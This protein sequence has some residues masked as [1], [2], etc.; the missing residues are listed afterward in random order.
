MF[1]SNMKVIFI[2]WNSNCDRVEVLGCTV[3]AKCSSECAF[4]LWEE[5]HCFN[6]FFLNSETQLA[7]SAVSTGNGSSGSQLSDVVN[8]MG[9]SVTDVPTEQRVKTKLEVN[10]TDESEEI[11]EFKP[12][13]I[14]SA[15][16]PQQNPSNGG[17]VS[18]SETLPGSKDK[19]KSEEIGVK[20][21]EEGLD[22][23]ETG[24]G[25]SSFG[26]YWNYQWPKVS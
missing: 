5:F 9:Q 13:S 8:Q 4:L 22:N 17:N 7:S 14:F 25:K 2:S 6:V 1:H 3:Y 23:D 11:P 20:E 12:P 19:I 21:E 15:A 10:K 18:F 26:M 24:D 16:Q